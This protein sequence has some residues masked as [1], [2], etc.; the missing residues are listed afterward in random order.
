MGFGG[1]GEKYSSSS[2]EPEKDVNS[3]AF[4]LFAASVTVPESLRRM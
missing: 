3:I 4:A 1:S 2:R